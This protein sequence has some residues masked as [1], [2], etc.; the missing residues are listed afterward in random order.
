MLRIMGPVCTEAMCDVGFSME[1]NWVRLTEKA[2]WIQPRGNNFDVMTPPSSS[3]CTDWTSATQ[4]N[5]TVIRT[6]R[7]S[8]D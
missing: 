3:P 5:H 1:G 4:R 6:E 2:G 7:Y 8:V